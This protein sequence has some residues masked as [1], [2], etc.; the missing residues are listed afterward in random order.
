MSDDVAGYRERLTALREELAERLARIREHGADG[1][2]NDSQEQVTAREN[3]DVVQ[4]L[5]VHVE[6]EL[7]AVLAA[8][9]RV[10]EGRFGTCAR[11]AEPIEPARLEVLPYTPHCSACA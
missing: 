1:V 5:K 6:D 9:A 3:D 10:D 11:C 7:A 8:L 4:S 2:P